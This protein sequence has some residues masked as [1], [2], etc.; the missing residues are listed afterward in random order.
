M[1]KTTRQQRIA[2]WK[3]WARTHPSHDM[4]TYRQFRKTVVGYLGDPDCIMVPWCGMWVG[5]E[6]DGYTHT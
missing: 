1:V 6:A 3:L 4:P 5:I 2:L